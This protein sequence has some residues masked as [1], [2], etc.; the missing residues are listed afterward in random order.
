MPWEERSRLGV[1]L[2]DGVDQIEYAVKGGISLQET[3][4]SIVDELFAIPTAWRGVGQ[5]ALA[6]EMR[7][8]GHGQ[9]QFFAF[10]GIERE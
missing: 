10:N 1:D 5:N 7:D 3:I 9:H 8:N 6:G 4:R 2:I